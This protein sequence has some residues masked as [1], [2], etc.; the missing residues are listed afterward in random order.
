MFPQGVTQVAINDNRILMHLSESHAGRTKQH[1]QT[2]AQAVFAED[3]ISR[4]AK[5]PRM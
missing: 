4:A 2:T 3:K 1:D 5:V